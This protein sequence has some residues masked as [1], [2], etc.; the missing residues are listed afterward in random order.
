M[1][2]VLFIGFLFQ[3]IKNPLQDS[4]I[5]PLNEITV[6]SNVGN[7][8]VVG[9]IPPAAASGKDIKHAVDHL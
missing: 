2:K 5:H 3:L 8:I 9:Q 7:P 4:I 1:Q 6:A